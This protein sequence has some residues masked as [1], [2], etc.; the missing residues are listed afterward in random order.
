[1]LEDARSL[2]A[3]VSRAD[4]HKVDE[5]LEAVRSVER[6]LSQAATA[7]RAATRERALTFPRPEVEVPENHDE[8]LRL[9]FDMIVLA[10]WSDSTRVATFMLDHEQTNRYFNF[11]PEVQGM[12][13][14]LSHWRDISGKTEDDD[15]KTSWSS[16]EKKYEQYLKVIRYHHEQVAYFLGHMKAIEEGDGTLLDHSMILYGSPFSDGNEHLSESL[17]MLIAGRAGGK[18][19]PGRRLHFAEGPA[20]G[21]YLSMM[22][23]MGVAV[24]EIG[25]IDTAV[26]IT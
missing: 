14:A 11:L 24:H 7:S 23:I 2:R 21:V 22:D 1:M 3:R 6:R 12:W 26:A 8:Y 5:Y 16:R 25:G 13:H 17:P 15:G 9:M 20:E 19:Q 18:I 10:F 4:Q